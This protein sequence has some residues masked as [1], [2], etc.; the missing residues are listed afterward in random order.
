MSDALTSVQQLLESVTTWW[1]NIALVISNLAT[2]D[3]SDIYTLLARWV[4]PVLA[5]TILVRCVLPLLRN[6]GYDTVWGYLEVPGSI[7]IPVTHWENS[8]G[9]SKLSD[10]V[11]NLPFVSRSH[12]VLTYGK[13]AWT[14]TDLGSK[15]GVSVNGERIDQQGKVE[16]GDTISLGGAEF[17]LLPADAGTDKPFPPGRWGWLAGLGRGIAPGKTL[18]WIM[19]FQFLGAFQLYFSGGE[20]ANLSILFTFLVLIA[21]ECIYYVIMIQGSRKYLELEL[22]AFFLCGLNLLVVASD[23]PYQLYKQLAAIIM[24]LVIFCA[25]HLVLQDLDR[26]RKVKYVLAAGAIVLLALNLVFG[27]VRFGARNWINLGFITFQPMELVKV[28]FVLAGTATLDRLLTTR[29]ITAFIGF[30]GTCI[31][32]L[33]L[34]RD[35]GTAVVFF[36]A[37]LVIAFM[38]SGD[39]RTIAYITSAAALGA[40]AAVTFMPYVASRFEAWGHVWQYA[41][42]LGFQQ[43]RTMIAAASGGLLG[44]GGGNGYLVNIPAADTDLVFG[45]LCEE[46]G[47]VVA[48]TAVL[49]VI[50]ISVFAVSLMRGCKSSVYAIAAA[51]TA[52]IFLIQTALNVFGSVDL[53]PL[54]GITLP[55]VSNGG[56]SMI[57]SWALLAFIKAAD[58]RSRTDSERNGR[59]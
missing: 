11:V 54:T 16:E 6:Q 17:R 33:I 46:W 1:A 43:T 51:G 23:V 5:V 4:F 29:N 56:S 57:A 25:L 45:L 10:I 53:L 3:F 14:I 21:A 28:A 19:L 8:L 12:A 27:E 37:F 47:L 13:D 49:M 9:R 44:V 55:F 18:L 7:R 31:G 48:F 34:M 52:T 41:N 24:G 15:G 26:A 32:A 42:S 2:I 39:W 36:G 40:L 50:F 38:R 58:D 20:E 22:L 59:F 30:A 35:L